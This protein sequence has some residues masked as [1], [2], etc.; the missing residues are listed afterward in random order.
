MLSA[1]GDGNWE[2]LTDKDR[3]KKKKKEK[4]SMTLEQYKQLQNG[5]SVTN[6]K[7]L[8]SNIDCHHSHVLASC[9][10]IRDRNKEKS[11]L[12]CR[13]SDRVRLSCPPIFSL[14]QKIVHRST[15]NYKFRK[16][17]HNNKTNSAASAYYSTCSC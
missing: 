13:T 1:L 10:S 14:V 11:P 15:Q 12:V 16:N 8:Y 6:G 9:V 2:Q 3:R 7:Q 17:K 5:V 4:A